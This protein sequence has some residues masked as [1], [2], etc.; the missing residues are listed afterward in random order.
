MHQPS[1]S[2]LILLKGA[3]NFRDIGG[4]PNQFGQTIKWHVL[5]RADGLA[6][7]SKEDCV[8][9]TRL[10]ITRICDLRTTREQQLFPD[11]VWEGAQHYDCHLY[12]EAD[13]NYAFADISKLREKYHLPVMETAYADVYQR[14]LLSKEAQRCFAKIFK[15]FLAMPQGEAMV[16]HCSAG[17]DRT[18]MMVALIMMGLDVSDKVIQQDYLLTNDLSPFSFERREPTDDELMALIKKMNV[19]KGEAVNIKGFTDTIRAGWG[20]FDKFFTEVL[21][22]TKEDLSDLRKKLL[23]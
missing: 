17:K 21:G 22:F 2:R 13:H 9:L 14:V 15:L 20:S 6:G 5:Y 4:Y 12:P 3:H 23:V 19:T 1:N 8:Q 16:I 11:V 18:G 10:H 7:L